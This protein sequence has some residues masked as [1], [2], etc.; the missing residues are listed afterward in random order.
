MRKPPPQR[1][2][3]MSAPAAQ[4]DPAEVSTDARIATAASESQNDRS[5]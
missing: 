1:N 2:S 4:A 3:S 5:K